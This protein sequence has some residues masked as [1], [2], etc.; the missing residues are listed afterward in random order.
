MA[1]ARKRGPGRPRLPKG[2]A[3]DAVLPVRLRPSELGAIEKAADRADTP[4][5]VWAREALR[6]AAGVSGG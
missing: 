2:E 1:K 4:V 3:R 5:G 6:K